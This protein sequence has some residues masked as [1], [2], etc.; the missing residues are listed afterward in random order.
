MNKDISDFL[1]NSMTESFGSKS[2]FI[3]LRGRRL[4]KSC[5][6]PPPALSP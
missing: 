2:A 5:E 1:Q 3:Y 4:E 6:T